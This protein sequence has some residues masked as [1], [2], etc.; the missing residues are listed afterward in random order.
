MNSFECSYLSNFSDTLSKIKTGKVY[1]K[2]DGE[3]WHRVNLN[4]DVQFFE[5]LNISEEMT[6]FLTLKFVL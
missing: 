5:K 2:I 1:K 6:L 3:I 4:F